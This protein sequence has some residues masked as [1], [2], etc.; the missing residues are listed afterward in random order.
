MRRP[1][2]TDLNAFVAVADR[3]SFRAA[4]AHLGLTPSALSHRMRQL[5]QR[6]GVRLL[7]RTTRSVSP[8][9]AGR[10]LLEQL[11]PAMEQ[12]AGAMENLKQN[13]E[14]PTGRLAIY[15]HPTVAEIVI[16]PI[17]RKFLSTY[18]EV[19]LE[20]GGNGENI[21]IVAAGYD[22]GIAVREFVAL[23]MTA[24]RV[25]P[26]MKI[27]IVGSPSYF[28]RNPVPR[29][30]EDLAKHNCIQFRLPVSRKVLKWSFTRKRTSQSF[31]SKPGQLQVSG[32]LTVSGIDLALRAAVDGLGIAY[33]LE[34]HAEF[35]LR[36]G[37][38]TRVLEDWSPT[39]EGLYLYYPGHRQ[40]PAA[41]RAFIDTIQTSR[42]KTKGQHGPEIPF[43]G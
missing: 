40:V 32:N 27:A 13:R 11:R 21:D 10:Q 18:P 15:A 1:D 37:H 28:A 23:D 42:H 24:V 6:M 20:I 31:S 43:I 4:A 39:F 26:P 17:W 5:E 16:E 30:P 25:T 3:L 35:F 33:T 19:N 29:S 12:I 8:T 36:S 38:L 9:D 7:H 2:L 41:L 14:R 22:A 34:A